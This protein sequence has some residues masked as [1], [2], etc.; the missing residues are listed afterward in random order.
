VKSYQQ[1]CPIARALD[2]VGERWT[3]LIVR[4]LLWGPKRYTDL[5]GGLPGIG[6][7]VLADRL[8]TLESAGLIEKRRLEPPAASTVYEL[9]A[10]GAALRSV[11]MGLFEWGVG[12]IAAAN[13][14]D[15]IR[16]SY[17][18]PAIEASLQN[19]S[20]DPECD[21]VYE[22]RIGDERIT[23][24]VARGEAHARQG[25]ATSPDLVIHTDQET[26]AALG[27]RLISPEQA[28]AAGTLSVEGDPA[29]ALRCARVFELEP[30]TD[31]AQPVQTAGPSRA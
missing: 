14:D 22:F 28:I 12:L 30:A 25:S 24:Q 11:L 6:P 16:A 26:F 9:T 23:V 29:A 19:A 20:I 13:D 2:L 5:Q 21:D 17:W 18:L 7:N 15:V 1:F 31:E 8:R 3:L 4:E 10:R 27:G